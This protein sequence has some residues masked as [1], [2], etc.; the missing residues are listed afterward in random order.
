MPAA[1]SATARAL[2]SSKQPRGSARL[3]TGHCFHLWQGLFVPIP[4][5][6]K[7]KHRELSFFSK[8]RKGLL[9]LTAHRDWSCFTILVLFQRSIDFQQCK[10]LWDRQAVSLDSEQTSDKSLSEQS[11]CRPAPLSKFQQG[12][13]TCFCHYSW[14][15][16][17]SQA[18]AQ[19]SLAVVIV[20]FALSAAGSF[21]SF[22]GAPISLSGF[23]LRFF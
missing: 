3:C 7:G 1:D 14:W 11:A 4:Y 15:D 10:R 5:D 13:G 21:L 2:V 12:A 20:A 8:A 9:A 16:T 17:R 6:P 23:V 18:F 22:H 19:C